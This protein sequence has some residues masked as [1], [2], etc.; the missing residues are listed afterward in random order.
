MSREDEIWA[1]L[2]ILPALFGNDTK[3]FPLCRKRPK[4]IAR[5]LRSHPSREQLDYALVVILAAI[6][7]RE[8]R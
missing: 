5:F 7:R 6:R 8:R 2:E 1:L 4:E 3:R